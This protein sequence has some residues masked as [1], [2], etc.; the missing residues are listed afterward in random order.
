MYS[1]PEDRQLVGWEHD[2]SKALMMFHETNLPHT[3]DLMD[4]ICTEGPSAP[5]GPPNKSE[6]NIIDTLE[7]MNITP[8]KQRHI[9][10]TLTPFMTDMHVLLDAG[11]AEFSVSCQL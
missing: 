11:F 5:D 3:H 1:F 8:E 2:P 6:Q 4:K 7:D 9:Q 10:R